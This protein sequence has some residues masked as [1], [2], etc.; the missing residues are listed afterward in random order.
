M[1]VHKIQPIRVAYANSRTANQKLEKFEIF[2]ANK[3]E[4]FFW[5]EFGINIQKEGKER[6]KQK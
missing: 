1:K 4:I 3:W 6:I 2:W 5:L